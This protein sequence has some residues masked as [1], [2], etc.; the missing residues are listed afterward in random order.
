MKQ[1]I[2]LD[3]SDNTTYVIYNSHAKIPNDIFVS[4]RHNILLKPLDKF[5][6]RNYCWDV[7]DDGE[8]LYKAFRK[9]F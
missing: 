5:W 3:I 6:N 9:Y 1:N 2:F 4:E 8:Y 7:F